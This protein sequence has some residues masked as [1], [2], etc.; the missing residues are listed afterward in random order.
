MKKI[1]S[2]HIN[3]LYQ[4][5]KRKS[6]I[7]AY[8][9]TRDIIGNQLNI[10]AFSVIFSPLL[11][12]MSK[13][14]TI[15][16]WKVLGIGGLSIFFVYW[17]VGRKLKKVISNEIIIEYIENSKKIPII[18][19]YIYYFLFQIILMCSLPFLGIWIYTLL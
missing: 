4:V 8:N 9:N 6:D 11:L 12:L 3:C 2:F 18:F 14:T 10:I 7:A 17:T 19:C 1:I 16:L 15:T 13:Y 5:S